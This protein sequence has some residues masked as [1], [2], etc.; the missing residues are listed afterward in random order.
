MESVSTRLP[1]ALMPIGTSR[2]VGALSS[3]TGNLSCF[4]GFDGLTRAGTRQPSAR[5]EPVGVNPIGANQGGTVSNQGR[6][7]KTQAAL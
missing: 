2:I 4:C 7:G 1:S 6:S 3:G 5:G